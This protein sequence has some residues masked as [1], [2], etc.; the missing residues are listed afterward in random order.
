[1]S[2]KTGILLALLLLALACGLY[3]FGKHYADQTFVSMAYLL[4]GAAVSYL[5]AFFH[6]TAAG[7]AQAALKTRLQDKLSVG[8]MG[9]E[10]LVKGS[11]RGEVG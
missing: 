8:T 2:M 11:T 4:L 1:M 3:I 10:Q 5:I 9:R 7:Q 6:G